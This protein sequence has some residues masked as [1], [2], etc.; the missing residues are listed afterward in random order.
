MEDRKFVDTVEA[1]IHHMFH[2]PF[3][4]ERF[5][6]QELFEYVL[7]QAENDASVLDRAIEQVKN[8][9]SDLDHTLKMR[10]DRA[11]PAIKVKIYTPTVCRKITITRHD[12]RTRD[13]APA[14]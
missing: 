4:D 8:Q 11:V 2:P 7:S 12:I 10:V 14:E 1:H 5:L 9:F 3:G 13:M 6:N